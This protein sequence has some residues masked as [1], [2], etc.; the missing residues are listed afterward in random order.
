MRPGVSRTR[1]F[2]LVEM[3]IAVALV[4]LLMVGLNFFVFSMTEL[5]GRGG[6]KRLFEQHVRAVTRY[7]QSELRSAAMP[8]YGLGEEAAFS[9]A[10]VRPSG[11]ASEYLFTFE[12]PEGSRLIR[13]PDRPL[14]EVVCHLMVRQD[15]GLYLLWQS[16][17]ETRFGEDSPREVLVSPYATA[18]SYDYFDSES[19]TWTTEKTPR[20]DLKTNTYP[21]P[22]RLRLYFVGHGYTKEVLLSLTQVTE[23]LPNF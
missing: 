22:S 14:P 12:L 6:D 21:A 7:L 5:W 10:E 11:G 8:P 23:G 13:W 4:G 9:I 19:S 17:L 16:R 3:M 15:K 1:A 18:I 2:T 20:R